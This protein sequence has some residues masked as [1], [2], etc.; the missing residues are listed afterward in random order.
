MQTHTKPVRSIGAMITLSYCLLFCSATTSQFA[1]AF[2][3][4]DDPD[5]LLGS[6]RGGMALWDFCYDKDDSEPL[7][8]DPRT[9]LQPGISDGKAVH[10]NVNWAECHTD[11]VAVQEAGHPETCGELRDIFYRGETLMDTGSENVAALFVGNRYGSLAAVGGIA[12][13]NA[14]QYN[15]LW[16][17]WGGYDE[18]PEQFDLLVSNRY[19]S[20]IAEGRNPYPLVGED[21]N[22]TNGGSGQLPEMFT[23]VRNSDGSWSG[24]IGVT[25]HGCHSGE[26]GTK[27]DGEDLGFQFGGSSATDLNLF[28]RDMLP[29]GY[30]ASGV[31]PLN[32]TQTRGTNNA[33]AVNIAFLFPDKG[34]PSLTGFLRILGS[35][36]TGSM[37]SPNW[38]N[39]GHRPAKFVD[40][41]F[42][43]DAPRVD[44][45][46][47]TPILG[48]FGGVTAGLGEQGQDWMREHGP[49]MNLWIE[50][51]K[52]PKYPLPVDEELAETGA[53]LF[54]ELDMWDQT[55]R[56]PIRRPE[57]NGSC[58]SCHGAYSPRYVNNTDYLENPMLEGMAGYIVP[59]DIIDTDKRRVLTNT[60]GM[61]VT[62]AD[63]FFGYPATKGTDND[64]G[65]QNQKRLRGDRE[66]GYLA[67]PLYGVWASA[68]YFH[69][70][71]VPNVWE[72]LKPQDRK[73]IWRR[74]SAPVPEG[75]E[76]TA[77]MGF[78]T[79]LQRAFD[80]EKLGWKYDEIACVNLPP[81]VKPGF[82]CSTRN[83][84][85]TPW[86]QRLLEW[87]YGSITGAWNV[88]FPPIVTTE[89][90]EN[91]KIYNTHMYSQGN[92]G[93]EF[94]AVL[95]DAERIAI[96]E[97]LKT[98]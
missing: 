94:T 73:P 31:T 9:L 76:G 54:H 1:H 77:V 55:R 67:Q 87:L 92:E 25:C 10:F 61:Q 88:D 37:D 72:V 68:P 43:M 91:R 98:L 56:N 29:L 21:P 12:T 84:N 13:F 40:G 18:R 50:T 8:V 83:I 64:C 27:E 47:Y 39:M 16:Q 7:P 85:I 97:Y 33:S 2:V 63:N 24:R 81:M 42:P 70:G 80:A 79:S 5:A 60:E 19:G 48:L 3:Y 17:I 36:S 14:A 66:V 44:A 90:M 35:G 65:P 20:G 89:N 59:L 86:P 52:A 78:D 41:L 57:G 82:N 4:D 6:S 62:G 58:A 28:L 69:N 71:S 11:P 23:Q 53:V 30:L 51:L 22:R 46:F 45:V 34:W 95:T 49:E 26:I 74:V 15:K 32:L 93:H 38:W 75:V 96:I